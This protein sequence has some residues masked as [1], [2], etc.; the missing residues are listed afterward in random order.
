MAIK[1]ENS[2]FTGEPEPVELCLD[3]TD[4]EALHSK[5]LAFNSAMVVEGKGMGIVV[6]TGDHT[7]IGSIASLV[8][9]TKAGKST[10]EAE[11]IGFVH[12][13]TKVR[14][15]FRPFVDRPSTTLCVVCTNTPINQ[16]LP[17]THQFAVA[18][19]LVF[20]AVALIK[21]CALHQGGKCDPVK[22]F[23]NVFIV[24]LIANVPEGLPATVT[25]CLTVCAQRLARRNVFVKRLDCVETLGSCTVVASDKTGTLTQNKMT[26]SHLWI[27]GRVRT[28]EFLTR[29]GNIKQWDTFAEVVVAGSLCN[30]CKFEVDPNAAPAAPAAGSQA[31]LRNFH[32]MAGADGANAAAN[33][34]NYTLSNKPNPTVGPTGSATTYQSTL[35]RRQAAEQQKTILNPNFFERGWVSCYVRI[36]WVDGC[37]HTPADRPTHSPHQ[38]LPNYSASARPVGPPRPP[39]PRPTGWRAPPT[40]CGSSATWARAGPWAARAAT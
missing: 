23:I 32:P 15:P 28:T 12:F 7:M 39:A 25:S 24:V 36:G 17:P 29:E 9:Q 37:M 30:M 33:I 19:A 6:R 26:V 1:V 16:P 4:D 14:P 34:N 21:N 11:V 35:A 5:N 31:P 20:Y 2:S 38:H 13:I 3:K 22:S 8:G 27:D 40:S 18:S 10:L